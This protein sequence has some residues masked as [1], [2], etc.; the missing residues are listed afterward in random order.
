M[1]KASHTDKNVVLELLTHAF[2]N[3]KS[4]NYLI[5]QNHKKRRL[6]YELMDYSFE[7]CMLNGEVYLSAD[8]K[9]CALIM[10]PHQKRAS[11]KSLKLDL[12]LLLQTIGL[13]SLKKT[14]RREKMIKALQPRE[15]KL[16]LWFIGVDPKVQHLGIGT[17]LLKDVQQLAAAQK[18]PIYLETSTVQNLPWYKK[19][20]FVLYNQ[21]DLSY[22]LHFLKYEASPD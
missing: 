11:A 15:D 13:R 20:G 12:K 17:Q 3:N 9:A 16:Y 1:I 19:H 8:Q 7:Q 22:K 10:Y 5:K 18:L 4:V 14:L 21:L 2:E 6:L